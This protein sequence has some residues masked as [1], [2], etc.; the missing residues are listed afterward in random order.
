MTRA[1]VRLSATLIVRNEE[2]RLPACL[3]SLAGL[4]DEI[5]VVD[6]GSTDRT[7]AVAIAAGAILHRHPLIGFGPTKQLAVA[8]ATGDW[9]LSIDADERVTPPL[10][11][12]IRRVIASPD[13]AAGYE[14]PRR[15]WFLGRRMR[16]GGSQSDRVLRLFRRGAGHFTDAVV[17]ER[18][19]V[20]G[21]VERLTGVLDHDTIRTMAEFRAKI[22]RYAAL[23]AEEMARRGRRYRWWDVFRLPVN[24]FVFL[25]VRLSILDGARGVIWAAGSAYH[26]WRKYDLLRPRPAGGPPVRA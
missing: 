3:A 6:T 13:A 25:F 19:E 10:A 18:V 23:R 9:V 2:E 20:E 21:R 14:I 11:A 4:A 26:S 5:V 1:P 8:G 17:H 15:S 22:E 24:F 16:F 12:E 7:P